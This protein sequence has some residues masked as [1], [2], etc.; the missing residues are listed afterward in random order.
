MKLNFK[1]LGSGTPLLVL[2]GVFGSLDNWM[3]VG[4]KLSEQNLVYLIDA[5]NHGQSPHSDDFSFEVMSDD[6][7]QLIHDENM[8]KVNILGHS[9]GGKTAM[10]FAC[11]HS[12]LVDKLIVVDIAPKPYPPHHQKIFEAYKSV[13]LKNIVSREE[14]E[15]A[16]Q[17]IIPDVGVSQFILK[18]LTRDSDGNFKW[19]LNI[20]VIEEKVSQIIEGLSDEN[21]FE[22]PTL[23]IRGEN[24]DYV[25]DEDRDMIKKHF[26]ES[27]I[28][29]IKDAGHWVHAEKPE[30]LLTTVNHFLL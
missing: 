26:P 22:G 19:K 29:T 2:H 16:I 23:F 8:G 3:T 17:P 21:I 12:N 6:L 24:S 20:K 28:V 9:M 11:A 18:N 13:D 10:T 4:R 15:K 1:K 5:R 14:A 7:H 30:E 27:N 25:L